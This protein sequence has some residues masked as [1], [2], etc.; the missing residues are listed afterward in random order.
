MGNQKGT[1]DNRMRHRFPRGKLILAL[2]PF[3]FA[4]GF[5]FWIVPRLKMELEPIRE[6]SLAEGEFSNGFRVQI[7][8]AEAADSFRLSGRRD[9][10]EIGLASTNRGFTYGWSNMDF[11]VAFKDGVFDFVEL[12]RPSP[13]LIVLFWFTD[14]AGNEAPPEFSYSVEYDELAEMVRD[15]DKVFKAF[16]EV[17]SGGTPVSGPEYT[18]EVEDG[19]GGWLRMSGPFA[20]DGLDGRALAAAPVFPRVS[21]KLKL[22][23]IRDRVEDAVVID[24]PNPGF[25]PDG[26][27]EWTADEKPWRRKLTEAAVV[28]EEINELRYRGRIFPS[29]KFVIDPHGDHPPEA[30]EVR[31]NGVADEAGNRANS[32]E[33]CLLP[34]TRR[35]RFHGE[36]TRSRHYQWTPAEVQTIAEGIWTGKNSTEALQLLP[37]SQKAGVKSMSLS[38]P[39]TPDEK[40]KIAFNGQALKSDLPKRFVIV[41]F[42]G[43][44]AA[45]SKISHSLNGEASRRSGGLEIYDYYSN[46]RGEIEPGQRVRVAFLPDPVSEAFYFTLPIDPKFHRRPKKRP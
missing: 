4:A 2:L 31:G 22:R 3:L 20:I 36:L 25:N 9:G 8:A 16:E 40:W 28:V 14:E 24:I 30:F 10:F 19:G 23:L 44:E 41:V 5:L 15:D 45:S 43:E 26:F 35:L 21:P 46:W 34:G 37:G 11:E 38:R 1:K 27:P 6:S 33:F 42:V 17:R 18:I 13:G 12:K 7:L 29:P 39:A 32:T